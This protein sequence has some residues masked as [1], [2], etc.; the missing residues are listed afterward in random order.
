MIYRII[1]EI[2][3]QVSIDDR[4]F[5]II[6]FSILQHSISVIN[7]LVNGLLIDMLFIDPSRYQ[8]L[9]V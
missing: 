9:G 7:K 4:L 3:I 2:D 1:T 6:Y 5:I 8:A